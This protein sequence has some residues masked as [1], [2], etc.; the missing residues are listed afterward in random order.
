MPRE[1]A[2]G[3]GR[4][5]RGGG[6]ASLLLGLAACTAP[7]SSDL[8]VAGREIVIESEALGGPRHLCVFTPWGYEDGDQS[9]PL[10]VLVDG[11]ALQDFLPVA[12]FGALATLSGQYRE[13][14]V[15]G[16]QTEDRHYELTP[17]SD[18]PGDLEAIAKNGGAEAFRRHLREEV[19]PYVEAEYRLS[20]HR[21]ILGE[22]LAGLFIVDTFLREPELFQDAIAVS[23]SLWWQDQALSK[24]A[25]TLLREGDFTGRRL[26][27]S[28][29]DEVD[30]YPEMRDSITR[31]VEALKTAAPD[32]LEW[33]FHPLPDEHH[34][35]VYH[36]A[37]LTALRWLLA[38][39]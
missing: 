11:G 5:R 34:S 38:P 4:T 1:A 30:L 9:Y 8:V 6:L 28:V 33:C 3:P 19:L 39:E 32:G 22:S 7:Q 10:L 17:P 15:V 27:L 18:V 12:G 36:P 35:T 26:D 21:L 14:V 16:V 31:F 23:P 37:T 20:G 24:E 13:F 25:E 2:R 29:A